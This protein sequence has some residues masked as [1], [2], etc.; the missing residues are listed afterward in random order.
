M[1]NY[2]MKASKAG[3]D[4]KTAASKDL[5]FNSEKGALKI[6]KSGDANFTTDGSGNGSVTIAH[7]MGY[8]PG[9]FAYRKATAK[10]TSMSG[11]TEY[12]NAYFPVGAPNFYVK[13]DLLH[14]AIHAYADATNLYILCSGGK[15]STAM[16]FRYYILVEQSA[17]FSSA[18]SITT[19]NDYGFKVSKPGFDIAS[20]KEYQL[21]FSSKYKILQYFS[22]SKKSQAITLPAMWPSEIDDTVEEATYVDFTHGLGFAPLVFVFFDSPTFSNLLVKAP[23]TLENALDYFAYS[24]SYFADSTRVRVYFWRWCNLLINDEGDF[25][26]ETIT[27]RALITTEDLAGTAFP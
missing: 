13:D 19:S 11:T 15:A 8:P 16:Y 24:V 4:V 25:P 10:N 14:H 21:A 20:A 6:F 26:A 1:A 18:D 23:V 27:I 2:G 12:S 7:N 17:T 5:R 9:F 3:Q 22:V